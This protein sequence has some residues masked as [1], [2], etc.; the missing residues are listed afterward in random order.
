MGTVF[1]WLSCGR[2]PLGILVGGTSK[3]YF[4]TTTADLQRLRLLV[5]RK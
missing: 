5:D 1:T 4:Q 2:Y 3:F